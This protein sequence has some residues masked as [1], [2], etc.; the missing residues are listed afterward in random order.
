MFVEKFF[1]S[2]VAVL[3]LTSI[4][5][6]FK[7]IAGANAYRL[8]DNYDA[9]S[10]SSNDL[11]I[12]RVRVIQ[13]LLTPPVNES[14]VLE[15]VKSIRSDGSWQDIDYKDVSRTGF[16]HA[17][18]LDNMFTLS[19]AYKKHDSQWYQNPQVR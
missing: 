16:E 14:L 1:R 19:R 17:R 10:A 15:L 13:D 8:S 9:P 6:S 4:F 3:L 11:E 18:H 5:L 2:A 12:I 7:T